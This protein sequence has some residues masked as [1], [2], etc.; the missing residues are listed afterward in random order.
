MA[1]AKK[2]LEQVL[3]GTSDANIA[4]R[5][6][7][8]LLLTLGF[9]ERTSGGHHIFRRPG[10]RELVNIQRERNK[11][12]AYQVRQVRKVILEYRLTEL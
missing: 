6:L 7:R 2:V 11:A 5:D 12:K 3:R 1:S 8:Q 10:V 9:V 4:F